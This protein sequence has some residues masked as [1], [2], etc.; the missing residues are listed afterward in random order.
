MYNLKKASFLAFAIFLVSLSFGQ[1]IQSGKSDVSGT[2]YGKDEKGN[3]IPLPGAS[4]H[5]YGTLVGTS[6]DTSGSFHINFSEKGQ[7]KLISSFLGFKNDTIEILKRTKKIEIVLEPD[8]LNMKAV[9]IN[10]DQSSTYVS[11]VNPVNTQIITSRELVKAACCNLSE[12]FETNASVDVNYSDAISGAKQI[13]M[14][15]LAGVYSQIMVENIPAI[16]GLANSYG[17]SYIPG[18]WMESIQISKGTSTVKNGYESVTGQINVEYKKPEKSDKLYI[19][20]YGDAIARTELNFN[21]NKK[22]NDKWSTMLLAHGEIFQNKLDLNKDKFIDLP[23]VKQYNFMNRWNYHGKKGLEAKFALKVLQEQ[24]DGGQINFNKAKDYGTTNAYGIQVNTL[25]VEAF[26]KTGFVFLKTPYK[27][28]GFINSFTYHDQN[29]FFGLNKYDG[30][31]SSYYSNLL[32]QSIIKTTD[33]KIVVGASYMYD[34]YNE[35]FKDS[36]INRIE[37]VPGVFGEYTY[38]YKDVFSLIAGFRFDNHNVFGNFY[39]PRIHLRY[40][41]GA[42][43]TFRASAGKGYRVPNTFSENAS[44]LATSKK[45]VFDE[46]LMPE[47]AWNYGVF[48][49]RDILIKKFKATINL[50]YHRTDFKNQSIVDMDRYPGEI[51]FYNLKGNSF[52]NSFQAELNLKPVKRLDVLLAYRIN[53]V[54]STYNNELRSKPLTKKVKGLLTI[55]YAT[56]YDKWQFDYTLQYNGKSRLPDTLLNAPDI[57]SPDYFMMNTQVLKRFKKFELYLGMENILNFMQM[58]TIVGATDPFGTEFDA[59]KIWG[60][61]MGRKVYGGIRFILK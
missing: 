19:S 42:L 59:T 5:W 22:L 46:K 23:L 47:E 11:K 40:K 55:S 14:L 12:S 51:H 44:L 52:S 45:L 15:G 49:A 35:L 54:R 21:T 31:Q 8:L 36:T 16:R 4:L 43:T 41:I 37:S 26:S 39:T 10:P 18:P 33:H 48:M 2:V 25:R 57:Y 3:L 34:H 61:I 1:T 60:P 32:Y 7:Q 27:S 28:I 29:S 17:L 38:S 9:V 50:D 53:D 58:E 20:L 30:Q 6:T 13:E 24:R 56:K